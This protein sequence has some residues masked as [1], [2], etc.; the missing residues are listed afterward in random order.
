LKSLLI[1]RG[2]QTRI[3]REHHQTLMRVSVAPELLPDILW[4]LVSV[5]S[6]IGLRQP[7]RAVAF[8]DLG[9]TVIGGIGD[10]WVW[11]V[12]DV[13]N[14]HGADHLITLKLIEVR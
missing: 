14:G 5:D 4:R 11:F 10:V 8:E 6:P 7:D 3:K 13:Q 12:S 1:L 9:E 2:P